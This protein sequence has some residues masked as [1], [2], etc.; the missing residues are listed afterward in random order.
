MFHLL[1]K[2]MRRRSLSI[3]LWTI[4]VASAFLMVKSSTDPLLP[5][6]YDTAMES[7]FAQFP[8]GNQIIFDISVGFIVGL[9]IYVLVVWVPEKKKRSRVRRSLARQYDG[10]K[11]ECIAVFFSALREPY[12]PTIIPKLKE[13]SFFR[14]YFKEN[15]SKDQDRWHAVLNGLDDSLVKRLVVELEILTAEVHYALTVIDID[16]EDLFAFLKRLTEILYRYRNWTAD[17]DDVKQLSGF[18][19]SVYTGWSVIDGYT[20]KDVIAEMIEAI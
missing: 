9:F 8:T 15:V 14:E 13:R 6:L 1:A 18:L 4:F 20:D 12:D 17:Y 16:N 19:W 5:L 2:H 11:E 10:F 3:A 7:L